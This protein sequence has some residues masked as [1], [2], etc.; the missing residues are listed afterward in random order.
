MAFASKLYIFKNIE[1]QIILKQYY[2][3]LDRL[4]E[5]IFSPNS[6]GID[7]FYEYNFAK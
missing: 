7:L 5:Y 1:Y 6:C 3:R 2:Q 4:G